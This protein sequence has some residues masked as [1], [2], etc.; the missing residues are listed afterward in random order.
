MNKFLSLILFVLIAFFAEGQA[1]GIVDKKTKEF[2]VS[3]NQKMDYR[4]FGYQFANITTQKMICFSSH[5]T[6]V[7]ANFSRCPLG[8]YYDTEKM[9]LGDKIIYLGG[10]GSFAKMNFIAGNGKKTI[11]YLPKSSFKIK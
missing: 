4:V 11:F 2:S 7:R 5:D 9:K 1:P 3:A 6:D 10:V 8:S